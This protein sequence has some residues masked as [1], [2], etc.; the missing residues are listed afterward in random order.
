MNP[1]GTESKIYTYIYLMNRKLTLN[2]EVIEQAKTYAKAHNVS[3][4]SLIENYLQ[5]IIADYEKIP[6][7]KA[8]MVN[9]LS[10]I[11]RLDDD[12]DYKSSYLDY[13]P[14]KYN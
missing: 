7:K 2:K 3:L 5:K 11:A 9:E 4:S 6:L 10:G 1:Y 13:L 8:S 12:L 14:K